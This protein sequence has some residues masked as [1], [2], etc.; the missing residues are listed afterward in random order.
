LDR[1]EGR[2]EGCA[3]WFFIED[4]VIGGVGGFVVVRAVVVSVSVVVMGRVIIA[5]EGEVGVHLADYG[6]IF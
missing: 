2:V 3:K 5:V 1:R 4:A 6:M